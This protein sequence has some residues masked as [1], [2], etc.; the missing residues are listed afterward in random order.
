MSN[1]HSNNYL[2]RYMTAMINESKKLIMKSVNGDCK[3][4][5]LLFDGSGATASVNHLVHLLKP[6]LANTVVFVSVTE[7]YS[8]ILPWYENAKKLVIIDVDDNGLIDTTQLKEQLEKH[9]NEGFDI[10]GSFSACSNVTGVI[11]D[12]KK[13]A[14]IVHEYGGLVF[15][16]YAASAPYCPIDLIGDDLEG[17][18]F[19]IHKF[20]GGPGSSGVLILKDSVSCN[21]KICIFPGG[22]TVSFMFRDNNGKIDLKYSSDFEKR[23]NSGTPPILSI[24][25]AG[26][27]F[28]I[29]DHFQKEIIDHELALTK[30]FQEYLFKIQEKYPNLVILNPINNLY[31][32]PIFALQFKKPNSD[33]FYHY[34]YIVGLLCDLYGITSRGGIS[35]SSVF[36]EKLLNL[37][38][39]DT[40]RIKNE[41]EQHKGRPNKYGWVR[42]TLNCVHTWTD[43]KYIAKAIKTICENADKF[44][45]D[46]H[47][48]KDKNV[49]FSNQ[50]QDGVCS[51]I[52]L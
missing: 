42:L 38:D 22:G 11:Q 35:C 34:N 9:K 52:Y 7:H 25:K 10:I 24:I 32:L 43:V 31:R 48:D 19:S 1:T 23:E 39:K 18:F 28:A 15:F 33:E 37:T 5:K 50:C 47:F 21:D 8:N 2:G 17:I 3:T 30:K 44:E 36:A 20:A 4:Y 49:Y 26:L 14:R 16:D 12:T 6:K 27:V 46:Y 13:I 41:I 45:S 40:M 29:K 51:N